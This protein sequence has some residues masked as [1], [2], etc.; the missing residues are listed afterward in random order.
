M[1][2]SEAEP[3][4]HDRFTRFAELDAVLDVLV[5]GI[6]E[7]LGGNFV[8]AYLQGSFAI[9]D[10]DTGSDCDFIVAIRHDLTSGEIG[11][12]DE[13]HGAIHRL[14]YLPWRHRLE[15]SYAPLEALR[16]WMPDPR[17][18]PGAA[19][20]GPDWL[21]EGTGARG[22]RAYPFIYLDHGAR[23]LVRSEHDDTQVVRWSLREKGVVLAGPDPRDLVDPVSPAELSAEMGRIAALCL[24]VDL[25]PMERVCDQTFWVGLFCRILHTTVTGSVASKKAGAAWAADTLDQRWR[26][27]IERSLAARA[28]SEEQRISRADP[29][30]VAATREFVAYVVGR[31]EAAAGPVR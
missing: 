19:P 9:G 23:S 18:P 12:L 24:A 3:A 17:E 5:H 28:L 1:N 15:G 22:P 26:G 7:R 20:R 29:A 8:G 21:D 13:L 4:S 30:E 16:Q 14:P 10:A 27:L 25:Q 31:L 6:R 2:G 11:E